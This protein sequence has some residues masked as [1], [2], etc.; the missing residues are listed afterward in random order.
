MRGDGSQVRRMGEWGWYRSY[1]I[2]TRGKDGAWRR[3]VEE[4]ERTWA[5]ARAP[6][7][8]QAPDTSSAH[9]RV[10]SIPSYGSSHH[11][12]SCTRC[13]HEVSSPALVFFS[14]SV[15]GVVPGVASTWCA[16]LGHRRR[17][18]AACAR[19]RKEDSSR[20][21]LVL[22]ASSS[23]RASERQLTSRAYLLHLRTGV[24]LPPIV[25]CSPPRPVPA[26]P[27]AESTD[28]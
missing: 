1:V 3:V 14:S 25:L 18:L 23:H 9:R 4:Q 7:L 8:R 21:E 17:V 13:A 11:P 5:L 10:C 20:V 19:P 12:D 27:R 24:V 2:R 22:T 16:G 28:I 15:D 6:P 26:I